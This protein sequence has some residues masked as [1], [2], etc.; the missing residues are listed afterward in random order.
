MSY[1]A[2]ELMQI[3]S[4]C[5]QIGVHKMKFYE[6]EV[7]FFPEKEKEPIDLGKTTIDDKIIDDFRMSQLMID[8]PY[9]FEKEMISLEQRRLLDEA[10]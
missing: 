10:L 2:T 5:R 6:I 4:S 3:I 1:T 9:S 7:E 8:D